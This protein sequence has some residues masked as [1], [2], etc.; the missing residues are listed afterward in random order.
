MV[1]TADKMVKMLKNQARH[2]EGAGGQQV[3]ED[4]QCCLAHCS[5]RELVPQDDSYWE[6][7]LLT[8]LVWRQ[9]RW[10]RESWPLHARRGSQIQLLVYVECDTSCLV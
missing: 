8:D 4:F 7:A 9:D 6:E 10:K 2:S 3:L 1:K 5:L